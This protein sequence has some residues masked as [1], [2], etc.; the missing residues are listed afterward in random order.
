ML[1]VICPVVKCGFSC[2]YF[3]VIFPKQLRAK[4]LSVDNWNSLSAL[5]SYQ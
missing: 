5:L 3:E 1:F 2:M 4:E